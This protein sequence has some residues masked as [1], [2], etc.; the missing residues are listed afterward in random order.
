MLSVIMLSVIML[1]VMLLKSSSARKKQI[2]RNLRKRLIFRHLAAHR[3]RQSWSR[4]PADR[5]TFGEF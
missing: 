3:G 1:S 2:I 4:D 5:E